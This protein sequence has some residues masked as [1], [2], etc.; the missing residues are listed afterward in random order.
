MDACA[1]PEAPAPYFHWRGQDVLIRWDDPLLNRASAV[2]QRL[3]QSA[4]TI[5]T[6]VATLRRVMGGTPSR[7]STAQRG[8]AAKADT[9]RGPPSRD[10]PPVIAGCS[11]LSVVHGRFPLTSASAPAAAEQVWASAVTK[12]DRSGGADAPGPLSWTY[13]TT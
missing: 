4:M 13:R 6:E 10:G 1:S 11:G 7:C 9:G 12:L 8:P 5:T 2:V 3:Q